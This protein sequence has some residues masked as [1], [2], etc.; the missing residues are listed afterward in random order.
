[1]SWTPLH[2]QNGGGCMCAA[3]TESELGLKVGPAEPSQQHTMEMKTRRSLRQKLW[4]A[5]SIKEEKEFLPKEA[6]GLSA[7]LRRTF[8]DDENIPL[9]SVNAVTLGHLKLDWWD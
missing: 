5:L 6:T 1:M 9:C 3:K 7:P 8:C 2:P 4:G